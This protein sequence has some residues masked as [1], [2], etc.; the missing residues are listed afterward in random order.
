MVKQ[1]WRK[2]NVIKD[3][4]YNVRGIAHKE[5]ELDSGWNEKQIKI[6][7]ITELKKK[8]LRVQWKHTNMK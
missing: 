4:T 2:Q 7:A 3:A 8:K 5:E 1:K 6:A